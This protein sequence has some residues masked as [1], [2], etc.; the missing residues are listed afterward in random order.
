M[1]GC[2]TDPRAVEILQALP[3]IKK[4]R[5]KF[6]PYKNSENVAT[7]FYSTRQWKYYEICTLKC[8]MSKA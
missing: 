6:Q 4:K 2:P 3:Q 5:W 7:K 1:W 8:S